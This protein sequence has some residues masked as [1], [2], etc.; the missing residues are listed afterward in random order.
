MNKKRILV[1]LSLLVVC[2]LVVACTAQVEET[3]TEAVEEG[4]VAE[5]APAEESALTV[6]VVAGGELGDM[7]F[8]DSA[9]EGLIRME[10]ELG[11]DTVIVQTRDDTTRYLDVIIS[12]AE[13]ADLIFVIPGYYFD[14]QLTQVVPE[15]PG[16]TFVY[17]DGEASIENMTSIRFLENE[18][19][20]LAGALAAL[21]TTDTDMLPNADD[22]KFVGFMGGAD[23][24]V[25]HNY[26]VGFNQ[27]AVYA[28]ADVEV[29]N[30]FAGT[31]ID[32][33]IGKETAL[34]MYGEGVDI[35][36]Q[37]AGPTGL[38]V[39]EAAKEA[40]LYVI[41]VDSNQKGLAP[42]YTIASM[43]KKVGDSIFDFTQMFLNGEI[44]DGGVY[45]YGLAKGG[46]GIDY[47]GIDPDLVPQE[48]KDTID[49]Y[50]QMIIDGE[51]VV[52]EYTGE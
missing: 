13:Q 37:A 39:F 19:A 4:T 38:G 1:A 27:G 43:R 30:K 26:L 3:S 46:V 34:A 15:Y 22:A 51:I 29:L 42:E 6:A 28:D 2:S 41:G 47:G 9:N 52:E 44:E 11:L 50:S 12:A 45:H 5:D 8:I 40:E 25:I 21:M 17:V 33:A 10:E 35:I 36:F 14:E 48:I 49:E 20:F 23:M 31:H 7:G 24:P 16:K 32:P 18:G